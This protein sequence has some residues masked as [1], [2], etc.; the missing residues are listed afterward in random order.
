LLLC[1]LQFMANDEPVIY[2]D[3]RI[4]STILIR[5]NLTVTILFY[6]VHGSMKDLK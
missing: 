4:I 2:F 6:S 1:K 3:R 5:F